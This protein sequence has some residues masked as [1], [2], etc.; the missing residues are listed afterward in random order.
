MAYR[1][2]DRVLAHLNA[3]QEAILSAARA[4][5]AESGTSAVQIIPVA[6][7]AGIAVGTVYRYFPS[8][9]DLVD[10]L[11]GALAA[12]ELEAVRHAAAGAPGPLSAVAAAVLAFAGRALREPRLALALLSAGE[13]EAADAGR[14]SLRRGLTDEFAGLIGTAITS[15]GL[16]R[17]DARFAAAAIIGTVLEGSLRPRAGDEPGKAQQAPALALFALRALGVPDARARG[18]ALQAGSG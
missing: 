12:Q 15:G 16:P 1:R 10:R 13:D 3:R 18:L 11:L 8:K 6:E 7:R 17:Q 4:L 9:E 2:T 14:L 5:T